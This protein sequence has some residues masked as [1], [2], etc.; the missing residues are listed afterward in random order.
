MA[1]FAALYRSMSDAEIM[2]IYMQR[3][4]LVPEAKEAISL[5]FLNRKLSEDEAAAL[6]WEVV[7]D[8]QETIRKQ[9]VFSG[10][11]FGGWFRLLAQLVTRSRQSDDERTT[12]S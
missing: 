7:R 8:Q 3:D 2:N 6:R 5:E 10:L 4:G 1:N 12:K 11:I 9:N